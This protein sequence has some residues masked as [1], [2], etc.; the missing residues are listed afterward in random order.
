MAKSIHAVLDIDLSSP[1]V[2]FSN[3]LESEN[4]EIGAHIA[5]LR[6]KENKENQRKLNALHARHAVED[7]L[8]MMRYR[9]LHKDYYEV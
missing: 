1:E 7:V 4:F 9:H 6:N 3:Y 5:H 2:S 8:E